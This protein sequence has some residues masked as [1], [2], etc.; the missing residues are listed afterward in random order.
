MQTCQVIKNRPLRDTICLVRDTIYQ[1]SVG[2][3]V[4]IFATT[5]QMPVSS[6]SWHRSE[7]IITH[8]MERI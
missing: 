4:K 3:G 6:F 7:L 2:E 8:V 1:E 5:S